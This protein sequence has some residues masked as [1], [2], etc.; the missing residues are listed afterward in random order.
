MLTSL[1]SLKQGYVKKSEKPIKIELVLKEKIFI[2]SER[3]EELQ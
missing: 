1:V 3:R 2:S